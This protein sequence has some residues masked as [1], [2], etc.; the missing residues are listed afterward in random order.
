MLEKARVMFRWCARGKREATLQKIHG[1]ARMLA[2]VAMGIHPLKSK[3]KFCY[4]VSTAFVNA[5]LHTLDEEVLPH[6]DDDAISEE[7]KTGGCL[8]LLWTLRALIERDGNAK[9]GDDGTVAQESSEE[10]QDVASRKSERSRLLSDRK[11]SKDSGSSGSGATKERK[12]SRSRRKRYN[13][14][15]K[16]T[17]GV[18]GDVEEDVE[19]ESDQGSSFSRK[20]SRSKLADIADEDP[21]IKEERR[22]KIIK[23]AEFLAW[24]EQNP[25]LIVLFEMVMT[26]LFLRPKEIWAAS[27]QCMDLAELEESRRLRRERG[28]NLPLLSYH[29]RLLATEDVWWV[30]MNVPREYRHHW[31]LLFSEMVHGRSWTKFLANIENQG[32]TLMVIQDTQGKIFGGFASSSWVRNPT[33]YGDANSFLFTLRPTMRAYFP[34]H[35]NQH[36]QYLNSGTKTLP[37][38]L[39]MGGQ[40]DYFGL[41]LDA[42][43]ETGHSKASP[44]S[45]TYNSP[46]LSNDEDFKVKYVE[47]WGLLPT[48]AQEEGG[49]PKGSVLDGNKEDRA[50][51][52][53]SGK[54]QQS[55]EVREPDT[56]D[57][58]QSQ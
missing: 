17:A 43:F 5:L 33:F 57:E 16:Q 34:S 35:F 6:L 27:G 9:R 39:G 55:H 18:D 40:L 1:F 47:V 13:S 20:T 3:D 21:A 37:N 44:L 38:G 10:S 54:E 51:L 8:P 46:Q 2:S 15:D 52:E 22:K 24:A 12:K 50:I 29:T 31:R 28:L 45:T 36:F 32:P 58:A 23:K 56:G 7:M 48:S 19:P 14:F 41:F 4:V 49:K 42:S 11:G 53:W 30:S 25:H 26:R